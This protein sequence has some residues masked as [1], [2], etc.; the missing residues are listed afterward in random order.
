MDNI[1]KAFLNLF[2]RHSIEACAYIGAAILTGIVCVEFMRLFEIVL[3]HRLDFVTI[4]PYVWLVTPLSFLIIVILIKRFAPFAAGTGIPQAVYAARHFKPGTEKRLFPLISFPTL[5]VK[6]M[7]LLAAIA[8]GA[9]TGREGPTVH[10]AM[11]VFCLSLTFVRRFTGLKFDMRS[12]VV[13]GGAAGLAAAFNTP[14]AGVAFAIEELSSDVFTSMKEIVLIAIIVAAITAKAFTGDYFYFGNLISGGDLSLTAIVFI[15]IVSGLCGAWFS[16]CLWKGQRFVQKNITKTKWIY[17]WPFICGLI[18]VC[19]AS[20]SHADVMGPGN[21]VAKQLLEGET[22]KGII[23][24]PLTKIIA[25]L[26]TFWSGLAAGI[27]A[28]CLAVGAAIGN[29]LAGVLHVSLASAALIGMASFL[30]GTIQA[31]MTSFII[32]FEMTNDHHMLLPVMLAC[33]IAVV[34]ARLTGSQHLYKTLSDFYAE[35]FSVPPDK[36]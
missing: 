30:A 35:I 5:L 16:T 31:P 21:T 3:S 8:V 6:S 1:K 14:L 26:M 33:L 17:A 34:V 4:G 36:A 32:V 7:A 10:I 13:A 9:S 20:L 19:I 29:I 22:V 11:C 25:T 12:A 18:L 23:L 15:A 28:P 27:F 24:F 2:S